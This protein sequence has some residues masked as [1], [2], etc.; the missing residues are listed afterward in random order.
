MSLVDLTCNVGRKTTAE[1][2]NKAMKA[3]AE[4]ARKGILGYSED[5]TVSVDFN[6]NP[7]SAT[8]DAT[9]TMVMDG[10]VVKVMAWYDN[11][12]GFSNRMIDL[13]LF[14]AAKI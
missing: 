11:E 12:W 9:N 4:G 1:E 6:G 10:D 14:V 7:A 13:A 3:A 8:F 2:I 5:Q